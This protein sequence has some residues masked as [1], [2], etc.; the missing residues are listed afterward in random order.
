M[1]ISEKAK[2]IS[3]KTKQESGLLYLLP[4]EIQKAIDEKRIVFFQKNDNIIAFCIWIFY[5]DWCEISALYVD[6][7]YRSHGYF[8]I[9][10]RRL[11]NH[12]APY[13]DKIFFFTRHPAVAQAAKSSGF[14]EISFFKLPW[15]VQLRLLFH[16]LNIRRMFSYLKLLPKI[17]KTRMQLFIFKKPT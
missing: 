10:I 8:F 9:I 16:R 13:I 11:K 14:W 5:G 15:L 17:F 4:S 12:L 6:P 2:A 7:Q 1:V 3:L